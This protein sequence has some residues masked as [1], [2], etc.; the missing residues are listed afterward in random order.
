MTAARKADEIYAQMKQKICNLQYRPGEIL[1]IQQLAAEFDTSRTPVKE[2]I[3]RLV[4]DNYA[5]QIDGGHFKIA[6]I[7]ESEVLEIFEVRRALES[8]AAEGLASRITDAQLDEL[9]SLIQKSRAAQETA[10][11]MTVLECDTAFHKK[12]MDFY[13]NRINCS[14]L[15]MLN[16]RLQRIRFLTQTSPHL[17]MIDDEHEQILL[18]LRDR[19]PQEAARGMGVHLANVREDMRRMIDSGSHSVFAKAVLF[20]NIHKQRA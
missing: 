14:V 19:N 4:S 9:A 1:L 13:G 3:I 10:D 18:A 8:M 7:S 17:K 5:E 16:E 20:S 6:E 11:R 15:D 2:A 12:L